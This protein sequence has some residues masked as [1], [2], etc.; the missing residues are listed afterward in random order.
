MQQMNM[1][2]K[3]YICIMYVF[4]RVLNIYVGNILSS[5]LEFL[6]YI[7]QRSKL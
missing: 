5:L 6:N 4:S 3:E 1:E 2:H 7:N